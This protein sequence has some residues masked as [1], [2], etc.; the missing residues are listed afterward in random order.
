[1]EHDVLRNWLDE[2][3]ITLDSGREKK[4][5]TYAELIFETNKQFNLT[6]HKTIHDI[7]NNLIIGSLE[8]FILM[9]VPRGTLFADIG[10]GAGIPGV[11]LAIYRDHWKGVSIDSN[12][13]KVS[14]VE[15]VI[16][17]CMIENLTVCNG[18][19][20]DLAREQLRGSFDYVFSRA[21]GEMFFVIEAGAP[22]LKKGGLLYIY[23]RMAPRE[24][25][26][27]VR[28]HINELGLSLLDRSRYD[29]YG[30]KE[31]GILLTKTNTTDKKFPRNMTAIKRDIRK[32]GKGQ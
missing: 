9:N 17:D 31:M 27:P 12:S 21:L 23:S 16:R 8:P 19:L 14:F 4:L 7:I 6:G 13:K 11:P 20:E 3:K 1:M 10:T 26:D 25:P 22:L 30:I 32:F 18:R 15:R 5:S 2:N 29:D 28:K 24:L